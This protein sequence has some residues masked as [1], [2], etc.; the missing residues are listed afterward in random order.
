MYGHACTEYMT[1]NEI[2]QW[3]SNIS[4]ANSGQNN[5]MYGKCIFDFMTED[6]IN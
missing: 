6:Q 5:P 3:K 1:E 4:K 2:K